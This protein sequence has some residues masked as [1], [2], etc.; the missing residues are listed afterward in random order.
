MEVSQGGY[1]LKGAEPSHPPLISH[2][3]AAQNSRGAL[4][5]DQNAAAQEH[6]Q[7]VGLTNHRMTL[8][9]FACHAL[10]I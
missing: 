10:A 8:D 1:T 2:L 5:G 7:Q 6:Q 9:C 3:A 4:L